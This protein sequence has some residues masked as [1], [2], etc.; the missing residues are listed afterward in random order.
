M[1]ATIYHNARCSNSRGALARLQD[2][3]YSVDIVDYLATPL[4]AARLA[5]LI[6]AAG[7]DVRAAMRSKEAVYESLDLANP[8]LTDAELLAAMAANPVLLN[9]PFVSTPKGTRLC[10][11]PELVDDLL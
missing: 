9:R 8:A 5:T 3:G 11:P 10:R 4:N 2:A 7:L 6:A 1:H